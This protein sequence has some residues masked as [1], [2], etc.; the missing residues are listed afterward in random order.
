MNTAPAL[1]E[2]FIIPELHCPLCDRP[3]L[4]EKTGMLNIRALKVMDK[5]GQWWSHCLPCDHWFC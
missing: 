2:I 1:T 4:N 3:E 5:D